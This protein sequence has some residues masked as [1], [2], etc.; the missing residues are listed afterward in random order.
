MKKSDRTNENVM[1]TPIKAETNRMYFLL[2]N[3]WFLNVKKEEDVDNVKISF[4][5]II[6]PGSREGFDNQN[7]QV[8]SKPSPLKK[9]N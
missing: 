3:I 5:Q 8:T 7:H 1:I 6:L 2:G 9:C 4:K